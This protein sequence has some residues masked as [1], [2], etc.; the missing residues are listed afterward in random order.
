[1]DDRE[2][3]RAY[4]GET[5]PAGKTDRDTM[6]LDDEL[7]ELLS[8]NADALYASAAEGWGMKAAEYANLVDIS[9]GSATR[10]MSDLHKNALAMQTHYT[11]LAGDE[12]GMGDTL[13]MHIER[14]MGSAT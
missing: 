11:A 4:L 14:P 9:E 13:I 12:A 10:K 7:E 1:V 3:L 8:R 2:L 6:F 5:I